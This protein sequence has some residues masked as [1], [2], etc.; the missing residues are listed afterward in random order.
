MKSTNNK[1][2][3]LFLFILLTILL[4]GMV[5]ATTDDNIGDTSNI[6]GLDDISDSVSIDKQDTI[7]NA[8][9]NTLITDDNNMGG[10]DSKAKTIDKN[11]DTTASKTVPS[12][13]TYSGDDTD[14]YDKVRELIETND[15][16]QEL[17]I[18]LNTDKV[19]TITD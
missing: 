15:E 5:Y 4:S 18:E 6:A 13:V 14:S 3:A 8:E 7:G 9:K 19:Y 17:I 2:I 10:H 12:N 11:T 1:I 16:A